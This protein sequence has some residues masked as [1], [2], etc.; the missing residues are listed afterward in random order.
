MLVKH[1]P[2]QIKGSGI[3]ELMAF[4]QQNYQVCRNTRAKGIA[5]T[6]EEML[7]SSPVSYIIGMFRK[8]ISIYPRKSTYYIQGEITTKT[9][10]TELIAVLQKWFTN[11]TI[12]NNAMLL[13]KKKAIMKNI[14][15]LNKAQTSFLFCPAQWDPGWINVFAIWDI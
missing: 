6:S 8:I 10:V 13:G 14:T 1:E 15:R 3:A 4:H 12:A 7:D 11:N 9:N 2:F 5:T